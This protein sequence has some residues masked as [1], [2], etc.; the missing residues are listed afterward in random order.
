MAD[1]DS[2]LDCVKVTPLRGATLFRRLCGRLDELTWQLRGVPGRGWHLPVGS[3]GSGPAHA[4][5][6]IP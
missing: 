1:R 4:M 2:Q 3:S 6:F 5:R